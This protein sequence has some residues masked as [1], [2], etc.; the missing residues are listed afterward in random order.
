MAEPRKSEQKGSVPVTRG[1]S[2]SLRP[3]AWDVDRMFD[4]LTQGM[5]PGLFGRRLLDLDAFRGLEAPAAKQGFL[6]PRVDLT[7]S[8]GTFEIQAELPGIDEKD[9]EVVVDN[10]MLT[11]KGEKSEERTEKEKNYH[12]TERRY[13]SFQRSFQLPGNVDAGRIAARFDKGVLKISLPKTEQSKPKK[14]AIGKP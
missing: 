12:L 3:M 14:I 13:G 11:I 10:D 7:E 4:Q 1:G 8:D 6:S 2:G 5:L 9:V